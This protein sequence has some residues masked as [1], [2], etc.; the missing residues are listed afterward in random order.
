MINV[1]H[2][3]R[4]DFLISLLIFVEGVE[5][6][7]VH[8]LSRILS[9]S[10]AMR[11]AFEAE[12]EREKRGEREYFVWKTDNENEVSGSRLFVLKR[13]WIAR[14]KRWGPSVS[15]K[16]TVQNVFIRWWNNRNNPTSR[17]AAILL[18]MSSPF[19]SAYHLGRKCMR[20]HTTCMQVEKN[21]WT[22]VHER[23][24][25]TIC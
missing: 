21:S 20:A 16:E 6:Q 18:H 22:R 24:F 23:L 3:T 9:G 5:E 8:F 7:G 11:I 1:S 17:A 10:L 4:M 12:R 13:I 2:L 15:P 19:S 14:M 25:T